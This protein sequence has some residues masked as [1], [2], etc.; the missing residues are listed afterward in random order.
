MQI[1]GVLTPF[2]GFWGK[3]KSNYSLVESDLPIDFDQPKNS[4]LDM[5]SSKV[6]DRKYKVLIKGAWGGIKEEYWEIDDETA[7][8]FVDELNHA[9]AI[10]CYKKQEPQYIYVHKK[11]W[12]RMDELEAILADTSLSE[13]D[14]IEK[15]KQLS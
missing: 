14:R 12:E 7:R 9:H 4:L 13:T 11:V 10:C 3:I 6:S 1:F 2:L 8:K 5:G 15:I